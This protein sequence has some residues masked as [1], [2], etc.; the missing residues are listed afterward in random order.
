MLPIFDET[1]GLFLK[2][3]HFSADKHRNQ[4]RKDEVH[5]P[6]INH[7]LDVTQRLWDIGEVRDPITLISAVLHDTLEDTQTTP[8]EICLLF[9]EEVLSV[10]LEVTDDKS[11]PKQARKRLQ[12]EHAPHISNK[13]KLIKLADKSCNLY[14]LLFS[15]PRLWSFE[16]RQRYLLWTEQVVAGLRGTNPALEQTYDEIVMNGKQIL[17]LT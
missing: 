3:I 15:P 10:V 9:G 5:S 12:I 14:D 7:P 13:A 6:Y 17:K 16:R 1:T 2:A 11:L 8:H 4:R